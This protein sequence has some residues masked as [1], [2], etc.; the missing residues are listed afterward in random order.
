VHADQGGAGGGGQ[1][2]RV[3]AAEMTSPDHAYPNASRHRNNSCL[4]RS[5]R[6]F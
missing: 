5:R 4:R 6:R 2:Q 3:E 1:F